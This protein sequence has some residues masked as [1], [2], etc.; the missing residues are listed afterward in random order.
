MYVIIPR[1]SFC[2]RVQDNSG[3]AVGQ[4]P[5]I[6]LKT[7][8][9]KYGFLPAE[10]WSAHTDCPDCAPQYAQFMA[11]SNFGESLPMSA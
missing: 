6:P 8:Q 1:C 9:S 2:E 3:T 7:Y 10:I 4:G 11:R 5:W